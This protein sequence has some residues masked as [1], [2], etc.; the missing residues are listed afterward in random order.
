VTPSP[1]LA[2]SDSGQGNNHSVP[3]KEREIHGVDFR[4][5]NWV[6]RP[7]RWWLRGEKRNHHHWLRQHGG[8]LPVSTH[9]AV[10]ASGHGPRRVHAPHRRNHGPSQG[11]GHVHQAVHHRLPHGHLLSVNELHHHGDPPGDLP[12]HRRVRFFCFP[13]FFTRP[14]YLPNLTSPCHAAVL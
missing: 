14:P 12:G 3:K 1:S 7:G 13:F 2:Q 6:F 8:D 9:R 11:R 10:H 5:V 4:V